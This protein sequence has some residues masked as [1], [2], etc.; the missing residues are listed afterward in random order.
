MMTTRK[1]YTSG[2]NNQTITGANMGNHH[3]VDKS[4][5]F[6]DEGMTLI[7]ETDSDKYLN[8]AAKRNRNKKKEEL[9]PM[10]EE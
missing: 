1:T 8:M 4:Q 2:G 7:T 9:Y 10:P 3:K 5:G 6:I